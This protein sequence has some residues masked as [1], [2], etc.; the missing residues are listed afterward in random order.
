LSLHFEVNTP[1]CA[2]KVVLCSAT[3][4][5][6]VRQ[7]TEHVFQ[8]QSVFKFQNGCLGNKGAKE[9]NWMFLVKIVT[10]DG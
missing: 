2:T 4:R 3:V 5:F 7:N 9:S 6:P 1:H 8:T 10:N